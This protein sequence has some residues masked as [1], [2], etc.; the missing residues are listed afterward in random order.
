VKD[1]R[2]FLQELEQVEPIVD[3]TRT[4]SYERELPAVVKLLE[5]RGNP[6]VCFHDV[7]DADLP[8]VCGV[9]GTRERIALALDSPL[10]RALDDYVDRLSQPIAPAAAPAVP[11][12]E[13]R[14]GG[15]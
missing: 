13:V 3:V 11:V 10:D 7:A 14:H 9:H 15:R 1:L 2:S 12:K 6:V 8:V 5:S 4:V